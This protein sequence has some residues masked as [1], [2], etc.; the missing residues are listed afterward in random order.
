MRR[1]ASEDVLQHVRLSNVQSITPG[2][3][4]EV[5]SHSVP[6]QEQTQKKCGPQLD[7]GCFFGLF[8]SATSVEPVSPL[9]KI[10]GGSEGLPAAV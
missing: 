10:I 7:H 4:C 1:D 9:T 2:S 6:F 5:A 3:I 8:T